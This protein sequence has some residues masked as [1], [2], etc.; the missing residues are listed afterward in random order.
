VSRGFVAAAV[1][2]AL[3]AVVAF[4]RMPSTWVTGGAQLHMH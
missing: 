2:A 3:V 4:A 1:I